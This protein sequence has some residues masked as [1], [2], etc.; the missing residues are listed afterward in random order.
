MPTKEENRTR[1]RAVV[2]SQMAR[3]RMS[4]ADVADRAGIDPGTLGDFLDGRRWPKAPTQG[5]IED[6]LE[7]ESGTIA[8]VA[9]GAEWAVGGLDE[10]QKPTRDEDSLL[11]QRPEG[12]SDERWSELRTRISGYVDG[13]IDGASRER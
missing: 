7:L 9:A 1:A 5:K 6:A 12:M 8:T 2:A 3:L 11:F 10:D 13:L 4:R